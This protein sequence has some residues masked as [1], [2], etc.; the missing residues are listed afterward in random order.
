MDG[1]DKYD[2][3]ILYCFNN[4]NNVCLDPILHL[5]I[6]YDF[7]HMRFIG[8]GANLSIHKIVNLPLKLSIFVAVHA[9]AYRLSMLAGNWSHGNPF[10]GAFYEFVVDFPNNLYSGNP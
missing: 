3:R 6:I 9:D 2:F 1:V 8:E 5:V 4:Q 7:T 10:H